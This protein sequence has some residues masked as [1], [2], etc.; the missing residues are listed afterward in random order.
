MKM[1][2]FRHPYSHKCNEKPHFFERIFFTWILIQ[3]LVLSHQHAVPN[4]HRSGGHVVAS[5]GDIMRQD[6]LE[7]ILPINLS[8]T[9]PKSYTV[10]WIPIIGLIKRSSFF[11]TI[12]VKSDV[13][14]WHQVAVGGGHEP[15]ALLLAGAEVSHLGHI[16]DS[17]APT[18]EA[19]DLPS[20]SLSLFTI[21]SIIISFVPKRD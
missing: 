4:D 3:W 11:V 5:D 1:W 13:W 9:G 7:S 19:Q 18:I 21:S 14:N 2:L 8:L 16:L 17:Q 15:E 6:P 20:K 12:S 10:L